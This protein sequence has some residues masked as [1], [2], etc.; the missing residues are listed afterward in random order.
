MGSKID[1][2]FCKRETE[3]IHFSLNSQNMEVTCDFLAHEQFKK[4]N[5]YD[6][7][8]SFVWSSSLCY[9]VECSVSMVSVFVVVESIII[10]V[11]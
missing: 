8:S 7:S 10:S 3:V 2:V 4:T 9:A 5:M 6:L 1:S 11:I